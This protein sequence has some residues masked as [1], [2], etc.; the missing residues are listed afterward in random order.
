MYAYESPWKPIS[1]KFSQLQIIFILRGKKSEILVKKFIVFSG[2]GILNW[3]F[4]ARS[5]NYKLKPHAKIQIHSSKPNFRVSVSQKLSLPLQNNFSLINEQ[6][7]KYKILVSRNDIW[8]E[9]PWNLYNICELLAHKKTETLDLFSA[10]KSSKL[11]W[12]A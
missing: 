1:L 7:Q 12:T 6:G 9:A 4:C 8:C 10:F 5:S 11:T 2:N 3:W